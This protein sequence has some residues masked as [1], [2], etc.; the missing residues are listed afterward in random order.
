[1]RIAAKPL[2][3]TRIDA[4]AESI[5]IQFAQDAPVDPAKLIELVQA[6]N[7]TRFAGP[8]RLRVSVRTDDLQSRSATVRELLKQMM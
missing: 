2:G 1:L 5:T 4:S 6:R 7:D 8:E 3:I